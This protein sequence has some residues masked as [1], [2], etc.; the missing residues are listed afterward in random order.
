MDAATVRT[1]VRQTILETVG[2]GMGDLGKLVADA[3]T[4]CVMEKLGEPEK[5]RSEIPTDRAL[6]LDRDGDVWRYDTADHYWHLLLDAS[7]TMKEKSFKDLEKLYE[8]RI[9][10]EGRS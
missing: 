9:I 2:A 6:A 1:A 4:D 10:H 3:V 8:A 7:M 5:V